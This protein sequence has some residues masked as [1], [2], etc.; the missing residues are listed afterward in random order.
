MSVIND[1]GLGR[2]TAVTIGDVRR[3]F[4]LLLSFVGFVEMDP[5]RVTRGLLTM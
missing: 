5:V 2:I 1:G 4:V 3:R